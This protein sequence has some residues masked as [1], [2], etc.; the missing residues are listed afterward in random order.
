MI[1]IPTA[2]TQAEQDFLSDI[3]NDK[4][5]YEAGALL[6]AST[7]ALAKH[8]RLVVSV[9]PHEGYPATD[10]G[11]T[12]GLFKS[13][14]T[15]A[16]VINRVQAVRAK[17]QDCPP[18][19]GYGFAF[20]DL[21]GEHDI[22]LDFLNATSHIRYVGIHDYQR[23]GCQGATQAVDEFLKLHRRKLYRVG[24]LILLEAM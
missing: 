6:G 23:S 15:I 13:N 4:I 10:P 5:V 7:I 21:T 22:T 9:D 1:D 11:S 20:A 2:V 24:S 12:W 16:G 18:T 17:F 19:F 14:L 8:A 3:A